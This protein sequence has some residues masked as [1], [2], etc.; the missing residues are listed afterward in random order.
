MAI[1]ENSYPPKIGHSCLKILDPKIWLSSE[2]SDPRTWH[3][4]PRMQRWQVP[5]WEPASTLVLLFNTN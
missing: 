4:L 3:A 5:P 2:I 1:A